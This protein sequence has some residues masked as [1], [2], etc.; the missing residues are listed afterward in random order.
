VDDGDEAPEWSEEFEGSDYRKF[1]DAVKEHR[2]DV[3]QYLL[4]SFG[5]RLA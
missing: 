5:I 4:P 2:L 1:H 3:T